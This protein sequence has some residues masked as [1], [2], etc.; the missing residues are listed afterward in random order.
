MIFNKDETAGWCLNSFPLSS[1]C[2]FCMIN[3]FV[4]KTNPLLQWFYLDAFSCCFLFKKRTHTISGIQ[5]TATEPFTSWVNHNYCLLSCRQS[6]VK[7][8]FV[9]HKEGDIEMS[10]MCTGVQAWSG[11]LGKSDKEQSFL[12]SAASHWFSK[13]NISRHPRYTTCETVSPYVTIWLIEKIRVGEQAV[14]S[15]SYSSF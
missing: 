5:T 2:R 1:E 13:E 3:H 8:T 10:R 14:F 9:C 12:F 6:S 15:D 11:S 4:G 7:S